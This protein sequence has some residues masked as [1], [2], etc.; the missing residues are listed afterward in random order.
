MSPTKNAISISVLKR[1]SKYYDYFIKCP[2]E[3][4]NVKNEQTNSIAPFCVQRKFDGNAETPFAEN[5]KTFEPE[6]GYS[7]RRI[8]TR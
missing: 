7:C 3:Y 1:D 4:F 5:K 6:A 8:V 2:P